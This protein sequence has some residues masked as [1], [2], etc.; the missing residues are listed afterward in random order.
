M[1]LSD[2][3]RQVEVLASDGLSLRRA[4]DGG[5]LGPHAEKPRERKRA[6]TAG[7]GPKSVP[8]ALSAPVRGVET[9]R[10]AVTGRR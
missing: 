2:L 7:P 8:V 6:T 4:L 10:V 9:E 3:P 5:R 1:A